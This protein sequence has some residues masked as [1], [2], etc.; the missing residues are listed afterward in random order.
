MRALA[1]SLVG[2]EHDVVAVNTNQIGVTSGCPSFLTTASLPGPG[3][4]HE[5]TPDL[6]CLLISP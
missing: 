4:V 3:A 6:S 5:E 2:G 1:R